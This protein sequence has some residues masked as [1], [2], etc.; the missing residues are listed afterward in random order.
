MPPRYVDLLGSV[1]APLGRDYMLRVTLHDKAALAEVA[2]RY[3]QEYF[4]GPREYG[5]GG[6]RYDGRWRLVA[7]RLI[8][9][10]ELKTGDSVLDIGCG[11]GFL[12]FDLA[13]VLPQLHVH[14]VDISAYAIGESHPSI[15]P[16]L[17]VADLREWLP[18]CKEKYTLVLAVNVLH[19]LHLPDLALALR[20]ISL[21]AGRASYVVTD[22]YRNEREKMN[23]LYWQLTCRQFWTPQEW[24]W[25]M[26]ESGYEGDYSCIF[27]E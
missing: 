18:A 7:E 5:Y 27:Y 15:R 22:G 12:L 25:F 21:I 4:D 24:A 26:A 2:L 20:H 17:E 1:H 6:Y 9:R 8:E 14:G 10:Y 19:N 13:S 11:K 23:L 3:G 16:Y